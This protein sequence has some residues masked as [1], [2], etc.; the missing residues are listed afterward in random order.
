MERTVEFLNTVEMIGG[1]IGRKFGNAD[2]EC[3]LKGADFLFGLLDILVAKAGFET[4]IFRLITRTQLSGI[5][6]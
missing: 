1:S 5:P 2:I 6:Q 3:Y 4:A